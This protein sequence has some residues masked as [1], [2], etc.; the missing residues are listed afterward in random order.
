[1]PA[2]RLRPKIEAIELP[3]GYVLEWGGEHESSSD[4]QEALFAS[5]PMGY[6]AM[7]IITVLLAP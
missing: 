7:F 5:L 3:Q 2:S 4:A 6:L 1:M